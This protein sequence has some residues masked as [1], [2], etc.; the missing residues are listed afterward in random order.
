MKKEQY[1]N[2][3]PK[4]IEEFQ[5]FIN[6]TD[7]LQKAIDTEGYKVYPKDANGKTVYGD[8]KTFT[9]IK[10]EPQYIK[11]GW[12]AAD[13]SAWSGFRDEANI[14]Y[15]EYNSKGKKGDAGLKAKLEDVITRCIA[16]DME[17]A[18]IHGVT[19][20]N[21][22]NGIQRD[23]FR[24]RLDEMEIKTPLRTIKYNY[25]KQQP[26]SKKE[27]DFLDK[28]V[29]LHNNVEKLKPRIDKVFV[30]MIKMAESVLPLWEHIPTL[31]EEADIATNTIVFPPP[32]FKGSPSAI[33]QFRMPTVEEQQANIDLLNKHIAQAS[34][35]VNAMLARAEV[36]EQEY[37]WMD[38]L[39]GS[40]DGETYT[41]PLFKEVDDDLTEL[42]SDNTISI[43][44]FSIDEDHQTFLGIWDNLIYDRKPNDARNVMI[45]AQNN[46][47]DVYNSFM[48]F[49]NNK[50][51]PK[52][53]TEDEE[54]EED[55]NEEVEQTRI[56]VSAK[57]EEDP[58]DIRVET[59]KRYQ[60]D[61]DNGTTTYFDVN[62]WHMIMDSF[63]TNWD[64]KKTREVME[65]AMK[66]HP[67]NP[68]LLGRLAQMETD[69][70]NYKKALELTT[71]A[72]SLA[73]HPHPNIL[74]NKAKIYCQ[75]QTPDLAIPIYERLIRQVAPELAWWR[76]N[77]Y[78]RLIDV[79]EAKKD[80]EKCITLV[81]DAMKENKDD[82]FLVANL[83]G[84]YL[85]VEKIAEAENLL[86][87]F[88]KKHPKSSVCLEELGHVYAHQ[89]KYKEAIEY[90]DKSYELDKSEN[91]GALVHE[92]K[93]Y[94]EMGRPEYALICFLNCIWNFKMESSYYFL[95]GQAFEKLGMKQQ[96]ITYYRSAL[97][98]NTENKEALDAL[99]LLGSNVEAPLN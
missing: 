59:M 20:H 40:D 24:I 83:A 70:H 89:K 11:F 79:Y 82:E 45:A 42:S 48:D 39:S 94:M 75:L 67:E 78:D 52:S 74:Y 17:H 62:D 98:Y 80:Y 47:M 57:P 55:E 73:E 3:I 77:S 14:L 35:D 86:T 4:D 13:S 68:T 72:E 16:Y 36:M 44:I 56:D 81:K 64:N 27:Q 41:E 91:Y 46:F 37:D 99:K 18:L 2:H 63:K 88:I 90:Y 25:E 96:A 71:L 95:A 58:N 84:F 69:D 30:D 60:A 32:E 10:D 51:N 12:T 34:A 49:L 76:T 53:N 26:I 15:K 1:I 29:K 54:I 7:D 92:G 19:T 8:L 6:A 9:E 33:V 93:L 38:C 23:T 28:Y 97:K 66:Q 85:K 65:K 22:V 43:D 87:T 50:F 21:H 61:L 5:N 31:M